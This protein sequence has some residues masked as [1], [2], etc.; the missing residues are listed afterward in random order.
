MLGIESKM[1][2]KN[3]LA[4]RRGNKKGKNTTLHAGFWTHSCSTLFT[5]SDSFSNESFSEAMQ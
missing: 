3:L 2:L 4:L 5:A 1:Y